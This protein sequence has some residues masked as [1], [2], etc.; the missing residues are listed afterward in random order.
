MLNSIPPIAEKLDASSASG[1]V[2]SLRCV[3]H[4]LWQK[5]FLRFLFVGGLNT[6]FGYSLYTALV[7]LGVH[8]SWALLF[9]T[10]VG[11]FFNFLT[12]STLVFR[13]R[14]FRFLFRF[15]CVY[16]FTYALN[17]GALRVLH[18]LGVAP[19]IAQGI[20]TLPVALITFVLQKT[21][22]FTQRSDCVSQGNQSTRPFLK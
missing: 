4:F 5:R 18:E 17:G 15:L 3:F 6:A 8:Y 1:A 11:V 12:S 2:C 22:V 21:F 20:L 9:A 16:T 7:L 14:D 19:I 10:V 13:A